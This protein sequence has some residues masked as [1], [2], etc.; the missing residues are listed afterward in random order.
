[1]PYQKKDRQEY[2]GQFLD[3]WAK[4]LNAPEEFDREMTNY[5][6][7]FKRID[8]VLAR[9]EKRDQELT[10]MIG[11]VKRELNS[12]LFEIGENQRSREMNYTSFHVFIT[13]K[14]YCIAEIEKLEKVIR[15][16]LGE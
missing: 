9:L 14:E 15:D 8:A 7:T 4:G 6:D 16:R 13:F 11:S 2:P 3:M 5:N 1:M 12:K 10:E